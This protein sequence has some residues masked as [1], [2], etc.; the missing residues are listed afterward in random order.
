MRTADDV[1]RIPRFD[2]SKSVIK[3]DTYGETNIKIYSEVTLIYT[4][5]LAVKAAIEGNKL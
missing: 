1:K 4:T 2:T 5:W 3:V